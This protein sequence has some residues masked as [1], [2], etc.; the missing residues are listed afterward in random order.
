LSRPARISAGVA[1]LS[2]A[3][4]AP[5]V[6]AVIWR[7]RATVRARLGTPIVPGAG[8]AGEVLRELAADLDATL[9]VLL[10]QAHEILAQVLG[11]HGATG[12]AT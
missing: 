4:G 3:T 12:A 11:G 9:G 6:P 5:V 1:H 2:A 10:P 8:G 7:E